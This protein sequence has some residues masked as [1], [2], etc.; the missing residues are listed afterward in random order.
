M[1]YAAKY[2]NALKSVIDSINTADVDE[3]IEIL[4]RAKEEGRTIFVA[5]NGGSAAISSHFVADMAKGAYNEDMKNFRAISL[6]DNAS[7]ITALGNDY[8]YD[9][10]FVGQLRSYFK[11]G[12]IVFAVSASGNSPNVVKAVEYANNNG[13][14]SI[15]L[16]GFKGGKLNELATKSVHVPL[17]HYGLIEDS[18]G[19]ICHIIAYNFMELAG[20]MKPLT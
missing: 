16:C 5:G 15:G 8:S 6:C 10:I 2:L 12:D 7:F 18:H 14:S 19:I 17:E 4:A 13:G 11:P 1:S 3:V 20:T 9:D